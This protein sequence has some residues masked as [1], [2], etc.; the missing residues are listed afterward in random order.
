MT[1]ELT[2]QEAADL[3]GVHYMTAYRY[4]RLGMLPAEKVGGVWRVSSA[5]LS[6]RRLD[7]V[8]PA[9]GAGS[10]Q[11]AGRRRAPWAE[12]LE[13]RLLAGDGCGAW[14]VIEAAQAAGAE[15]DEVYLDILAPAMVS[16]GRRWEAGEIDVA[17]EHRASG[18]AMRVIG[19]L[20]PRF[21]RRG[22]SRGA[23]VLGTPAGERH[24]LPVALLADLLRSSGWMVSDL[25]A[26]LPPRSFASAAAAVPSLRAV[27]VSITTSAQ[28]DAGVEL[29][30]ELRLAVEDVSVLVGGRA[31]RDG[32]HAAALGADG[33]APDGRAL[34]ELLDRLPPSGRLRPSAA[35]A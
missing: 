1:T 33:W 12:R 10:A 24:C 15:L 23:V 9:A 18:I 28:L 7:L 19:R 32:A 35:M 8:A 30:E 29:V 3:L 4:V 11:R 27:G 5:A 31:V 22:R 6:G 26:D 34:V 14:N 17:E 25:G 2:L 13:S 21:T 16:I 20:G